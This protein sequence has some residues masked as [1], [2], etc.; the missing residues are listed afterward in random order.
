MKYL[1]QKINNKKSIPRRY[2][3][4]HSDRRTQISG[5]QKTQILKILNLIN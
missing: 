1:I 2:D 4:P 5:R 3:R